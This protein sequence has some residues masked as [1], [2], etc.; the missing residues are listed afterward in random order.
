M[1]NFDTYKDADAVV[2]A[3]GRGVYHGERRSKIGQALSDSNTW[4]F[5]QSA[6]SN[7]LSCH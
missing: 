3:I 5:Q 7:V 4:M 2:R 6:G 1:F